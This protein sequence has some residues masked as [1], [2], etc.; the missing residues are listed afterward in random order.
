M[1]RLQLPPNLLTCNTLLNALVR[2]PSSYSISLCKDIFQDAVRLGVKLNT[3]SFNILIYGYCLENKF[4]EALE[5][6]GKMD[7]FGFSPDNVSY[8]SMLDA[9]C[10]K[11]RLNEARD[12]LMDMK[13]SG[14]LPK[15]TT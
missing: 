5:L 1:K 14:L 8:N 11:G 2:H 9:F 6:L 13:N 10:K 3:N 15:R 12:L 7:E 4:N